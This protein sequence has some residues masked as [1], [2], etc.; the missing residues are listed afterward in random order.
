MLLLWC[1]TLLE[2]CGSS[3]ERGDTVTPCSGV[4][5]KLGAL[6]P[7]SQELAS[8]GSRET[9]CNLELMLPLW[10]LI[11]LEYHGSFQERGETVTTLSW[12]HPQAGG[13]FLPAYQELES[14]GGGKWELMLKL[15][16]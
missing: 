13:S 2:H 11:P 9:W 8:L 5:H 3:Q 14:L 7:A 1:L 6:F 4:T 16:S 10:C 15:G 12:C